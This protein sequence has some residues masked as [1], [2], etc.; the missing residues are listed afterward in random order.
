MQ[1]VQ[2]V[3]IGTD[4]NWAIHN[5]A[6]QLD[7]VQSF[8]DFRF[9]DDILPVP[10]P[11]GEAFPDAALEKAIIDFAASRSDSVYPIGF[12]SAPLAEEMFS[13]NDER[14]S[15]IST[16]ML[17]F[18]ESG[19]LVRTFAYLVAPALL[20][21]RVATNVHD[22]KTRRCPNDYCEDPE[23]ILL[24]LA[25]AA[26][27]AEC[28]RHMLKGVDRGSMTLQ[29]SAAISRILD[30]VG[31]RTICFVMMPFHPPKFGPVYAAIKRAARKA[32]LTCIRADEIFEARD[33]MHII[34]EGI[35]RAEVIVA[36]VTGR[37]ANVFYEL[38]LAHA[39]G[40]GTILITQRLKDSPFDLR[41]R[42]HVE[43]RASPDGLKRLE[44]E[45]L[46]YL[47]T[48]VKENS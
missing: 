43:Y 17:D 4:H 47:P 39:Q 25:R 8:F 2:F 41:Q 26:F 15:V 48:A 40:K 7:A 35:D 14:Y 10:D 36:D 11:K 32:G 28:R 9:D 1:R 5:L 24:G 27:C 42:K 6:T 19:D 31:G 38:G 33:I 29:E 23:E 20:D 22:Q 21:R 44:K 30:F 16:N 34:L 37:N 46:R 12:T 45:L 3:Q 13:V 18:I